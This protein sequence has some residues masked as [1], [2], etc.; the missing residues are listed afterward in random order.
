MKELT[1]LLVCVIMFFI[2]MNYIRKSIH[3][4]LVKS[5]VDGNEYYVRNLDDKVEAANKLANLSQSLLR[6]LESV[7]DNNKKGIDRLIKRFDPK[8]ITENIPGSLYVAYSV[9]KGDE[10]SICIREKK[11]EKFLDQNT[12]I[13]VA[14]HEIAHIMTESTG[15]TE[16]FWNNMKYLLKEGIK[17]GIYEEID[18][19]KYPTDYCGMEINN[20]PLNLKNE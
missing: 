4:S 11:T 7:K 9:N 12:V 1:C 18:Y 2:Y 19:A 6:L 13:F 5:T 16:E 10:L 3:L 15:H 14:I 17:I 20:T 8:N